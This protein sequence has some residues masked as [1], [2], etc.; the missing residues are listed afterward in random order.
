MPSVIIGIHGLGNK[1]PKDILEEWWKAALKDGLHRINPEIKLPTFE[2]V[3]WADILNEGALD[4]NEKEPDSPL[5]LSEPYLPANPDFKIENQPL[6]RK[7]FQYLEDHLDEF[8]LNKDLTPK[9]SLLSDAI[10]KKYFREVDVYFTRD[11]EDENGK[12]CQARDLIKSRF[13]DAIKKH[14]GKEIMVVTHSMGS[15]IAYDVMTFICPDIKIN[16]FVT[17]GSPL[18]LPF[19]ISKIAEDENFRFTG[20]KKL[21]APPGIVG[22][23]L[24]FSDPDDRIAFDHTLQDDFIENEF[25]VKARDFSI[26]NDYVCNGVRNPHKSFGYLRCREFSNELA[27]FAKEA[28]T[29]RK[30]WSFWSLKKMFEKL[31][32]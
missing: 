29:P 31:F 28:D 15:I 3:Y 7:M 22:Q 19:I 9:Y 16:S 14:D 10:I 1:P 18:G 5:Y 13:A 8:F 30:S 20:N 2:L 25:G 12:W 23:W 24:N 6:K 21:S 11:C 27:K 17:M 32:K 26:V 4:I